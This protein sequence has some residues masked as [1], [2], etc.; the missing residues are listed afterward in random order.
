MVMRCRETE[1]KNFF[2]SLGG[3]LA[4][5]LLMPTLAEASAN[6]HFQEGEREV[7]LLT[8]SGRNMVMQINLA[9]EG[10]TR[11]EIRS[12]VKEA[13]GFG[14]KVRDGSQKAMAYF[15]EAAHDSD[16][17]PAIKIA[18]YRSIDRLRITLQH[19]E[20][21]IYLAEASLGFRNFENML[22]GVEESAKHARHAGLHLLSED[23][24]LMEMQ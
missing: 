18:A 19:V 6:A 5:C 14:Q 7:A 20:A 10:R 12:H 17:S 2:A 11:V 16:A 3:I 22:S 13:I 15:N 4:L 1:S 9:S 23:H 24:A 8:E 21:A